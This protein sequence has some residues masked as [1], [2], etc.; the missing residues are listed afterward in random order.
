MY[1]YWVM[2]GCSAKNYDAHFIARSASSCTQ[3]NMI[4]KPNDLFARAHLEHT[5]AVIP[6]EE[7]VMYGCEGGCVRR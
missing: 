5:A 2:T 4:K 1:S 3:K 6:R 7:G